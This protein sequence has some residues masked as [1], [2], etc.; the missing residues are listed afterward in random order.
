MAA[1]LRYLQ[2]LAVPVVAAHPLPGLLGQAGRAEME[3][4]QASRVQALLM[5][6]AAAEPRTGLAALG[7]LAAVAPVQSPLAT[8]DRMERT[9]KAAGV[10]ARGI[11]LSLAATAAQV[12]L[13]SNTQTLTQSPTQAAA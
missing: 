3:Q 10:A 12:S 9:I 7:D 11:Y 5:Q 6:A 8:Q 2:R 1:P 4:P 13:S